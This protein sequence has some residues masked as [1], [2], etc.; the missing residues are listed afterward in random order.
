MKR[1]IQNWFNISVFIAGFVAMVAI[2]FV[3]DALTKLQLAALVFILLHFFEEFGWPGGF[4]LMGVKVLMSSGEMDKEKWGANNLS[5]MF[6]NWFFCLCIYVLPI[7]FPRVG[8]LVLAGM[9]FNFLE[10][11]MHLILFNVK[12]RT[13]YNPGLVTGIFGLGTIGC[14]YF[15]GY[16]DAFKPELFA[17]YDWAIAAVLMVAVFLFSFRSKLYWNLGKKPGYPFLDQTAYGD[18]YKGK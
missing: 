1:F 17:W 15:F 8:F 11:F 9:M 7:C 6:G 5:S 13:L 3:D 16:G 12:Q 10:V 14:L 2:L 4:P 18:G